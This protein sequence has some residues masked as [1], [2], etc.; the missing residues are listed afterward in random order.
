MKRKKWILI[1]L[2]IIIGITSTILYTHY[3]IEKKNRKEYS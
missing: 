1:A 3:K 2:L